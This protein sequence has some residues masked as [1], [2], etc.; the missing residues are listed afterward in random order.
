MRTYELTLVLRP[1]LKDTDRKKLID[2]I[3]GFAKGSKV[4]KEEEWGQKPLSYPIKRELAGFYVNYVLEMENIP[5][6]F[7]KRL[8]TSDGVLRHLLVRGRETT[9]KVA[10][11]PSIEEKPKNKAIKTKAKK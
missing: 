1:S 4:S 5:M 6:D 7:E 9:T 3:K 10:D 2:E 8:I 11:K